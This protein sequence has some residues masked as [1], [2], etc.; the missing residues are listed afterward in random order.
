MPSITLMMSAICRLD[1]LMPRMVSTTCRTTSPPCSATVE[2]PRASWLAICAL[3]AFWRTVELSCSMEAAVCCSALAWLSV[4]EDRSWLA[5]AICPLAAA[6]LTDPWCTWRTTPRSPSCMVC[7]ARSSM[8]TSSLPRTS[9]CRVRSPAATASAVWMACRSDRAMLRM[10]DQ[11]SSTPSSTPPMMEP[12]ATAKITWYSDCAASYSSLA[13]RVC[14][15]V[16]CTITSRSG[17]YSAS[18]LSI[19]SCR[20]SSRSPDS[21]ACW[22][23]FRKPCRNSARTASKRSASCAS[24][25]V[26]RVWRNEAQALF[27]SLMLVCISCCFCCVYSGRCTAMAPETALRLRSSRRCTSSRSPSAT[28][29]SS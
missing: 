26:I 3:S 4:R 17:A 10:M 12:T 20:A 23:G 8:D 14:S 28:R 16:S 19:S 21:S 1:S 27:T 18:S 15:A 13:T 5:C 24:S 29:R 25:S 22:A 7:S 11:P 9:M 6:T 2:A